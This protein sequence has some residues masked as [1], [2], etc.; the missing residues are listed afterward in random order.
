MVSLD[1]AEMLEASCSLLTWPLWLAWREHVR[2]AGV[3]LLVMRT[4]SPD[5][6]RELLLIDI[7]RHL[8][9]GLNLVNLIRMQH[10]DMHSADAYAQEHMHAPDHSSAYAL[11]I[12]I[13]R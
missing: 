8:D 7:L 6:L 3:W 2:H 4:I 1:R 9:G 5:S 11:A 10:N 13:D 12:L